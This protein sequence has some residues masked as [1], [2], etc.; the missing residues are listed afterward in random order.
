MALIVAA[1]MQSC[2]SIFK[3]RGHSVDVQKTLSEAE[4]QATIGQYDA[5]VIRSATKVRSIRTE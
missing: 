2:V 5:L 1:S 4:L 3:E